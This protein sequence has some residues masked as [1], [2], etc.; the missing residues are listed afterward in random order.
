[1]PWSTCPITV[2]TGGARLSFPFDL[3]GP[4]QRLL[5]GVLMNELGRVTHEL[6]HGGGGLLIDGLID[7]GHEAELH[8]GL[9]DLPG[10]HRHALRQLADGDHVGHLDFPGDELRGLE[11]TTLLLHLDGQ[12]AG[13]PCGGC[14][15]PT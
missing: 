7:G 9:D 14:A 15:A 12:R 4:L 2:T 6:H 5:H 10:L 13:E 3:Q 1:M 8:Q 11:F